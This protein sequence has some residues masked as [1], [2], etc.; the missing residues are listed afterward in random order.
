MFSEGLVGH[1]HLHLG[2]VFLQAELGMLLEPPRSYVSLAYPAK[3]RDWRWMIAR[4]DGTLL[5]QPGKVVGEDFCSHTE[6]FNKHPWKVDRHFANDR[7]THHP[8][9]LLRLV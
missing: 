4:I 7:W 6:G 3:N 1:L 9:S 5:S 8:H 2:A